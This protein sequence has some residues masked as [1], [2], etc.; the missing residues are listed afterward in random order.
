[1]AVG[2]A[3]A[4]EATIPQHLDALPWCR[5]HTRLVVALGITWL[6]DGLEGSLGGSLAAL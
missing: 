4:E 5:W 1:M 2:P 6:L 3:A